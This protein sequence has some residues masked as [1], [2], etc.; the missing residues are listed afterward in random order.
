MFYNTKLCVVTLSP[1]LTVHTKIGF[2]PDNIFGVIFQNPANSR[3]LEQL[4]ILN[5]KFP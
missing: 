2:V 4:Q 5:M 1:E 3:V